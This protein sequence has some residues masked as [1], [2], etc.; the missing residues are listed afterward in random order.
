MKKSNEY[1]SP[2]LF[3]ALFLSTAAMTVKA[4]TATSSAEPNAVQAWFYNE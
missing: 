1:L 3:F 2:G 4:T